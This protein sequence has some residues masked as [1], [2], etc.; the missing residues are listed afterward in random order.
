MV[1]LGWCVCAENETIIYPIL[2]LQTEFS[3]VQW[4]IPAR[5]VRLPQP[6]SDI[7]GVWNFQHSSGLRS[8]YIS[9]VILV[10]ERRKHPNLGKWTLGTFPFAMLLHITYISVSI[11]ELDHNN[12]L[13]KQKY[14]LN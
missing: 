7:E 1:K 3:V 11:I 4:W 14:F 12:Q 2:L 8:R 13:L 10:G 5:E 6:P 9:E